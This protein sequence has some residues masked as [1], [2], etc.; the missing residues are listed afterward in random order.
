[1][2]EEKRLDR[3]EAASSPVT[4]RP[5]R[6]LRWEGGSCMLARYRIRTSCRPP[7]DRYP[8]NEMA[9][10]TSSLPGAP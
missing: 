9:L 2:T 7:T 10:S 5:G 4:L 1:M 6:R 3:G 8:R